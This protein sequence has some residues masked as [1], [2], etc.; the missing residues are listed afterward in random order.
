[1]V[2]LELTGAMCSPTV[3]P[4][5]GEMYVGYST[6]LE[7]TNLT[8]LAERQEEIAEKVRRNSKYS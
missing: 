5:P 1:M 4:N 3:P 7:M 6:A 2:P 8:A